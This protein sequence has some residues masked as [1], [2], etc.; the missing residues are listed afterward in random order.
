V[1]FVQAQAARVGRRL[2]RENH[3]VLLR[4]G[5]HCGMSQIC[6]GDLGHPRAPGVKPGIGSLRCNLI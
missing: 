2:G 4:T 6:F 1:S 3:E 5:Q